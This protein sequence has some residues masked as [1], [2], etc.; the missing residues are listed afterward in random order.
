M[1][2]LEGQTVVA[3]VIVA[4]WIGRCSLTILPEAAHCIWGQPVNIDPGPNVSIC[5]IQRLGELTIV[6]ALQLYPS[7]ACF[8]PKT[9]CKA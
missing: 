7:N 4:G 5:K 2:N 9:H 6:V 3:I 8:P 1:P